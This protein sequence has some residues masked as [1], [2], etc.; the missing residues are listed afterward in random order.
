MMPVITNFFI[1]FLVWMG[2]S[3]PLTV[4]EI[5]IGI[6]VSVFVSFMTIDIFKMSVMRRK[7]VS[8]TP[9]R[10]MLRPLWFLYYAVV[11]LTECVKAN[12]D[13]AY[14]VLHPD[15]PI[16]PGTIKVKTSLTS[17]AGLTFLANSITLTPGT[18]TIDIEG[19]YLYVHWLYAR[20]TH[21]EHAAELIKGRF[22]RWLRRIFI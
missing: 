14:R 7:K 5:F 20:T 17:D 12:I 15:L 2:L 22:E 8:T 3:W 9:V 4:Q 13:V 16:N 1:W 10:D 11:F 19:E 6:I 21:F 18:I